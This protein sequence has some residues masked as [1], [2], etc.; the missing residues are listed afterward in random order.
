MVKKCIYCGKVLN[1]NYSSVLCGKECKNKFIMR[2]YTTH[3]VY[4]QN[5]K[6]SENRPNCYLC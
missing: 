5:N 6:I 2:P 3:P 1:N 4:L